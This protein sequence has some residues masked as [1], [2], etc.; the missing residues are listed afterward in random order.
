MKKKIGKRQNYESLRSYLIS[1]LSTDVD[2]RIIH[3]YCDLYEGARFNA[4]PYAEKEYAQFTEL[5]ER[6][7]AE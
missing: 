6:I 5:L 3:Q 1:T 4:K 7:R 2:A